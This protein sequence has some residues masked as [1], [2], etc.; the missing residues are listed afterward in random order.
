MVTTLCLLDLTAAFDTINY[1]LPLL[2]LGCQF[3]IHGIAVQWFRSYLQGRSFIVVY[4]GSTSTTIHI[5]CSVSQGSVLGL[6]LFILYK[7]DLAEVV[8]KHNVNI[9]LFSDDSQL[10]KHCHRHETATTV[11]ELE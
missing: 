10:Y 2:H 1:N 7:V 6:H 5:V 8:E 4:S 3:E 9:H 11:G